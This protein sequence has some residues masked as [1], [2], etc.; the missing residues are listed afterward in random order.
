M[1]LRKRHA[2]F[3]ALVAA[4]I[5]VASA[6]PMST[7]AETPR[8]WSAQTPAGAFTAVL[9]SRGKGEA[10]VLTLTPDAGT[11]VQPPALRVDVP[12]LLRGRVA[13]R[14]PATLRSDREGG[15]LR[16]VLP[17]KAPVRFADPD[18]NDGMMRV[19][20]RHCRGGPATCAVERVDIPLRA[21][22]G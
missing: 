10:L 16:A 19:E 12:A 1:P 13:G 15:P 11:R 22:S 3:A 20:F 14:F 4:T 6:P 7:A 17:L 9:E 2:A 21:G 8:L 18:R 5:G